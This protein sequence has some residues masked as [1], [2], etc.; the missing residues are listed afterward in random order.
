LTNA[1]NALQVQSPTHW[2][3][4]NH[5]GVEDEGHQ[6]HCLNLLEKRGAHPTQKLKCWQ[7]TLGRED[8]PMVWILLDVYPST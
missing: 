1:V 6:A 4:A 8:N 5:E 7:T 3:K 2:A